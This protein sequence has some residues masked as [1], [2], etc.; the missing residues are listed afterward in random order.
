MPQT[1]AGL[2]ACPVTAGPLSTRCTAAAHAACTPVP[3]STQFRHAPVA[4]AIESCPA[5][6]RTQRAALTPLHVCK[7]ILMA[8][9]FAGYNRCG[10]DY[11][12]ALSKCGTKCPLYTE[13]PDGEQ[14]FG[15]QDTDCDTGASCALLYASDTG[16]FQ[17]GDR[18]GLLYPG[19]RKDLF[20]GQPV[21]SKHSQPKT[22]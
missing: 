1:C 10:V 4:V 20:R 14:C 16:P 2:R 12:E 8:D 13:C 3:R 9:R 6:T 17:G 5:E 21:R 19:A 11:A 15:G 7:S 18:P 22:L